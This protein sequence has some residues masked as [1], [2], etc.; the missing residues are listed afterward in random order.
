MTG[1]VRQVPVAMFKYCGKRP[2]SRRAHLPSVN[3]SG[4]GVKTLPPVAARC[5]RNVTRVHLVGAL[6]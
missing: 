2:A 3:A 5:R 4:G 1:A 6:S